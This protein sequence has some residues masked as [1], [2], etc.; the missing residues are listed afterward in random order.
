[1]PPSLTQVSLPEGRWWE[2]EQFAQG[3]LVLPGQSRL[4]AESLA[5][6]ERIAAA[7][8][9]GKLEIPPMPK[10]ALNA[11]RLLRAPDSELPEIGAAIQ[12]DPAL[13]AQVLRYA[14]SALFGARHVIDNVSAA[15]SYL[16]LRRMRELITS[17]ALNQVASQIHA[18][19]YARMEWEYAIHCAAISKA[20]GK[21]FGVDEEQCYVAGLLQDIGRLPVLVALEAHG[22]L[23]A[24][25]E[26]DSPADIILE[27]LHRGVGLEIAQAWEE[28]PSIRDAI[29]QHLVGREPDLDGPTQFPSTR[30]SE[31]AG[32]IC[33]A[34]GIGRHSRAYAVLDSPSI[35][36]LGWSREELVQ[37]L[38]DELPQ[39][40]E[41]VQGVM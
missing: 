37:W 34:L 6:L 40:I 22:A 11:N 19:E 12:L 20:L 26:P 15:V 16:G 17:A 7:A 29:G 25:P 1:M 36:N 28:P 10:A 2:A 39:V 33:I 35:M 5:L 14:N 32:D 9:A 21:R 27:S 23:P 4:D 8:K 31:V 3:E 38:E 24:A 30:M 13:T 18:K 41:S